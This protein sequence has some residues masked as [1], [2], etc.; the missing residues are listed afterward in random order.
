MRKTNKMMRSGTAM[1]VL[2]GLGLSSSIVATAAS[3]PVEQAVKTVLNAVEVQQPDAQTPKVKKLAD[4]ANSAPT[5]AI[6]RATSL[7]P[8]LIY[9]GLVATAQNVDDVDKHR[10]AAVGGNK[11][12]IKQIKDSL[13]KSFYKNRFQLEIS[14]NGIA[15]LK[16]YEAEL[17]WLDGG[18]RH[19]TWTE[20]PF[21]ADMQRGLK[22]IMNRCAAESGPVY[23][24]ANMLEGD[25]DIGKGQFEVT[26]VPGIEVVRNQLTAV[27]MAHAYLASDDLPL[28]KRQDYFPMRM[29]FAL[30]EDYVTNTPHATFAD[31]RTACVNLN[32][33]LRDKHSFTERDREVATQLLSK[34]PDTNYN[35]IRK[36]VNIPVITR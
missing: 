17:D 35:W 11:N 23:F 20:R 19:Q 16:V 9:M 27:D 15:N 24:N 7:K 12:A 13:S 33:D 6:T 2:A 32:T 36:R 26:C 8:M 4:A 29:S 10:E 1:M 14:D 18:R 3:E 21:S 22:D 28:D 25:G 5:P 34:C 30:M 31:D